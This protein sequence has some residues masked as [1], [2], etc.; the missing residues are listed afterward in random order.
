[1]KNKKMPTVEQLIAVINPDLYMATSDNPAERKKELNDIKE[2]IKKEGFSK[3]AE[4]VKPKPLS[5]HGLV[6]DSSSE[7][8]E[9][10]YFYILDLLSDRGLSPEKYVDNFV[11]SPGSGHFAEL[12]QR[13]TIMQQQGAKILGD[14][15]TVLRSVLNLIY[16]L[17][18]FK[19]RLE[20]YN[21]LNSKDKSEQNASIL[22][23]KQIW[24]DRVDMARG[25]SSLKAMAMQ[26]G[27]QTLLHAFLASNTMKEVDDLDL[28]D[29]VKRILKPR[30]QEFN[31]WLKQ[32]EDELRKRY[33]LEKTYLRS[34]VNSLK[35]YSR[36][37]KPYLKAA[38][39]LEMKESG[40]NP[41]LVKTF[42]TILLEL[43]L[44]G[45][46]E[47]KIK[48]NAIAGSLPKDF[49]NEKFLRTQKRKYY[50]CIVISLAF[51]GIPQRAGG[52]QS[53]YVFGGK[54]DV[55]FEAYAL[56][57]DE[58]KKLSK[59]AEKSDV[60]DVLKLIEG[61]TT[62]SLDQMQK[63]IDE[64]LD[65][66]PKEEKKKKDTGNMNPFMALLGKYEGE[67]TKGEKKSE[68]K[69]TEEKG[70]KKILMDWGIMKKPEKK[71]DEDE[72]IK[73]DNFV[74]SE[75]IR[76]LAAANAEEMLFKMFDL[77]KK[78]HGMPSYT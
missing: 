28:N 78:V 29:V 58:L 5:S 76:P 12:G 30:L 57:E 43:T 65:E 1:M 4:K 54:T 34:Q 75:S 62:E 9:P 59:E 68:K 8:L 48:E 26:G 24:L 23:L 15:N 37:A 47:V 21:G 77:Y 19:I 36:W 7:T 6:Y 16:D 32:S 73:P 31:I 70:I 46:S 74:E 45:K 52:Q 41:A 61:T 35:L 69:T 25:N 72:E 49:A 27:F 18:D 53:H 40:R 10:I 3:A 66:K 50:T 17:K 20:S 14:V 63:E 39:Q 51:R 42:N 11:S 13:A 71:K 2:L 44:V 56:N 55:K 60:G 64:I 67:E 33:E 38:A 22:S